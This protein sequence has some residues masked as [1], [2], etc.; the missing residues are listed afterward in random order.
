MPTISVVLLIPI[1]SNQI[2]NQ[3]ESI[4]MVNWISHIFL[5]IL[6]LTTTRTKPFN[7]IQFFHKDQLNQN[8]KKLTLQLKNVQRNSFSESETKGN[9]LTTETKTEIDW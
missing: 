3:D 2:L 5:F 1:S 9:Q 4:S 7:R 8:S 6:L